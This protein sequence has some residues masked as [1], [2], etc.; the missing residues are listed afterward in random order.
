MIISRKI[1]EMYN[2]EMDIESD[3]GAGTRVRVWLPG[4]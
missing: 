3:T 1:V 4:E 2:G